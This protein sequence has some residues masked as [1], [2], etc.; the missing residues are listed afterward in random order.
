MTQE[1]RRTASLELE[2]RFDDDLGEELEE[3]LLELTSLDA[4]DPLAADADEATAGVVGLTR[5]AMPGTPNEDMSNMASPRSDVD[6]QRLSD[7]DDL[8]P[9]GSTTFRPHTRGVYEAMARRDDIARRLEELLVE[10]QE[11]AA[12]DVSEEAREVLETLEEAADLIGVPPEE[13]DS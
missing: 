12:E 13:S 11:W 6:M 7:D 2:E 10:V 1:D 9:S 4:D 8:D 5:D 3:D